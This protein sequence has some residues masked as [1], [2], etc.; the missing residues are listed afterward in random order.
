MRKF[1]SALLQSFTGTDEGPVTKYLGCQLI[2][3]RPNRTSQLVQTAYTEHLLRTFDMWD[4]LHTIATP[5]IPGT[6]L[7]KA[8]CPD[9]P[10]PTL[11]RRY[12]SII[13]SIGYLV[14]MTRCDM[15]FAYGQLSLFLH[16]FG[17]IHMA[18]AERAL[19][20]VRGTH[21]QGLSNCGPCA[22]KCNVLTGWVD[23]DFPADSDTRHSVTRYVMALNGAPIRWRS[24]S[25]GGVTLSSSEAEYLAASA[26]AQEGPT[27]ALF[28]QASTAPPLGPHASGQTML[29][30]MSEILINRDRSRHVNVKFHFL[31]ERVCAGEFKLY[32]CW[33]PLNVADALTKSLPRPAFHAPFMHGTRSSYWPFTD[34]GA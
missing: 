4:E 10:S 12:R 13:G 32:K 30:L 23:S 25:Q 8:D 20:Y 28:Y 11:Q 5:M 15:A 9:T 26:V 7:V 16:K 22:E 34:P 27:S 14:Q 3:D 33:G 1:K 24:C 6:R 17:P 2:R 21:E 31:R 18:A 29:H 19:A